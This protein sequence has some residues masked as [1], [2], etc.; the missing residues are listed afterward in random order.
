MELAFSNFKREKFISLCNKMKIDTPDKRKQKK[1]MK[2]SD[3][4][5]MRLYL[6]AI[7]ARDSKF[8]IL[9]E[10][11]SALDNRSIIELRGDGYVT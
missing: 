2:M 8:L 10:P 9:D 11:A 5:K 1:I 7:F 3:G 4:N 6:A